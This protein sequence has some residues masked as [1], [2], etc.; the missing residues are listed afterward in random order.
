M[1]IYTKKGD[2]GSTS[3]VLGEGVSKA[4]VIIE[5][6]GSIDEINANIGYLRSLVRMLKDEKEKNYID[7]MM[8]EI[9]YTLF[10]MGGDISSKFTHKYVSE[11]DVDFLEKEIDRMT[12]KLKVLHSF[13][14]YSGVE[15]AAFAHIVRSI[16][17]RAERIFVR[18]L[19]GKEYPPDYQ[20]VNRL[21]DFFY[22]LSR[23]INYIS[24]EKD[25]V[26]NLRD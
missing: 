9:Q 26:M 11:E 6:Q 14:Y 18:T 21:S 24:G 3:N 13:I 4:D 2:R 15:A 16:T 23:Y 5:L 20:Y 12:E 25:E 10:R 7:N 8:I 1:K 17:R 19:E 22:T